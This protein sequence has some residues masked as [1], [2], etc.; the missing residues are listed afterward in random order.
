MQRLEILSK[1]ENAGIVAVMRLTD[2][3]YLG[4]IV[5]ALAEGGIKTLEITMTS[6]NAPA[7]IKHLTQTLDASYLIG[8]GT[9]CR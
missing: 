2:T 3:T 4:E 5:Q 1:L 6:P 9:V 7:L 8:A